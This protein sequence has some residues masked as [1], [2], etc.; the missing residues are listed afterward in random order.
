MA[1]VD[2]KG[3]VFRAILEVQRSIGEYAAR[4]ER[5][6]GELAAKTERSIGDLAAK[7]ER[8]LG[9]L[10]VK[11]DRLIS[12]VAS[13]NL[14]VDATNV[15]V[16]ALRLRLAWVTRASAVVAFLFSTALALAKFLPL[17]AVR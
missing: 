14:R 17:A 5:S 2:E 4:T 7:T 8:S 15:K 3:D 12:D 1:E 13:L 10:T 16:D 11:T 6:I 9:E